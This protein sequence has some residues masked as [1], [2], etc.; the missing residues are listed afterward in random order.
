MG[1]YNNLPF[2]VGGTYFGGDTTLATATAAAHL[3][4]KEFIANDDSSGQNSGVYKKLRVVRNMGSTRVVASKGYRFGA[5]AGWEGRKIRGITTA[6]TDFGM[7]ADDALVTS[8]VQYDLFYVHVEGPFKGQFATTTTTSGT[9]ASGDT[10]NWGASGLLVKSANSTA[11]AHPYAMAQE[12]ITN[13]T[14]SNRKAAVW[15][16]GQFANKQ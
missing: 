14:T 2:P 4:G 7:G 6:T 10:L 11:L 12:A 1:R 13:G 15:V 8:V 9:I 3:E 16:G 5:T